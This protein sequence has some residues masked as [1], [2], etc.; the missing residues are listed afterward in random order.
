[1]VSLLL[2]IPSLSKEIKIVTRPVVENYPMF[3][4]IP[5][6]TSIFR[7]IFSV[8]LRWAMALSTMEMIN[9]FTTIAF[10]STS[11]FSWIV[12]ISLGASDSL[13]LTVPIII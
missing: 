3:L 9:G 5:S 2:R 10:W 4:T 12:A 11:G 8:I 6:F 1:M 13:P 7:N